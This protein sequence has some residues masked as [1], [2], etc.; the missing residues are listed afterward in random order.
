M[1]TA[2]PSA[3]STGRKSASVAGIVIIIWV[4]LCASLWARD[5]KS[6][7]DNRLT[8]PDDYMRFVQVHRWLD[9]GGWYDFSEPRINPPAGV[10]LHW[11]RL[12]D[13]P[14]AAVVASAE[15][16]FDRRTA[17]NIA[18]TVIPAA[19]L[20]LMLIATG[21]AG[22]PILGQADAPSAVLFT[23]LAFPLMTQFSFGRVDHHQWQLVLT[24]V[25]LGALFRILLA[26][27]SYF[28]VILA[29][30]AFAL[31]LWVGS[32]IIPWLAAFCLVLGGRWIFFGGKTIHDGLTFGAVLLGTSAI[33]L[34]LARSPR[35]LAAL[36]CDS[37]SVAYVAISAAVFFFW[38]ALWAV[39]RNAKST[40]LRLSGV[41]LLA[42]GLSAAIVLA[43]PSCLASPYSG[44]DP[45]LARLWLP[46]IEEVHSI[47]QLGARIPYYLLT[48]LLAVTVVLARLAKVSGPQRSLWLALAIHLGFGLAL[49]TWQARFI[50]FTHLFAIV[51][52]A[53]AA[54][55][56]WRYVE[57]RWQDWRRLAA[58]LG[59]LLVL[60]PI[61]ALALAALLSGPDD[62]AGVAGTACNLEPVTNA[63]NSMS[64]N[65]RIA[66]FIVPGGEI[67]YRTRHSVLA[68]A[69]H[70]NPEG[71]SNAY[72]LLSAASDSTAHSIVRNLGIDLIMICPAD[73]EFR[74]YQNTGSTTFAERLASLDAP[75][76]LTPVP[77]ADGTS[78]LLYKV[79]D[80]TPETAR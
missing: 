37:H 20:L 71:N 19:L 9:G 16:A 57:E 18:A 24:A 69:Y 55:A 41:A 26:P 10:E 4:V 44:L 59:S 25:S 42:L 6:I 3:D 13:L 61:P 67:L 60:S 58:I 51:P 66:G 14:I 1:H 47:F 77:M 62:H 38:F 56:F 74:F 17:D 40:I 30:V 28:P 70:R 72:R 79:I 5:G 53:W 11:T 48:P 78:Y 7:A 75:A 45:G 27:G 12:P 35:E 80:S 32:E 39:F 63:L 49:S 68:A 2:A 34:P 54:S 31:G 52:L 64:E 73:N 50:P 65:Q 29:G 22:R 23:A 15:P 36:A 21:W 43:F 33:A 76:W 46:N 8:G